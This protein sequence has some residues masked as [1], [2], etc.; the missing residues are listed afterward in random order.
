M[1]YVMHGAGQPWARQ[2]PGLE[3]VMEEPMGQGTSW[4]G[5]IHG[6]G[7]AMGQDIPWGRAPYEEGHP[8][9]GTPYG[10]G[11]PMEGVRT[12]HGAKNTWK[13]TPPWDTTPHRTG[14][15]IEGDIS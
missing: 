7:Q 13:R 10:G 15:P 14:H 5:T 12:P 1:E 6:A 2:P 9:D 4:S 3:H 8:M 11:H